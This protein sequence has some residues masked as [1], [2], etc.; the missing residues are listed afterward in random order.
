MTMLIF[1]VPALS[2]GVQPRAL[3]VTC[4][5]FGFLR[6]TY[7]ILFRDLCRLVTSPNVSVVFLVFIGE[8]RGKEYC[9]ST[10][11]AAL[12]RQHQASLPLSPHNILSLVFG[13]VARACSRC[14]VCTVVASVSLVL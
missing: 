5:L 1:L 13:A 11:P 3:G 9:R 2:Y 12:E 14:E 7:N 10:Q 4:L 8:V 6:G